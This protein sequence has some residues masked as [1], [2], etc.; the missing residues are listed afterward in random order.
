MS[1]D[2]V[3]LLSIVDAADHLCVSRSKLYELLAAGDL[4]SVRIGRTRRIAMS[5]LIE[6]VERHVET[7]TTTTDPAI[8][9]TR[10]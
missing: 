7:G 6:F 8:D 9:L 4:P 10:S 1:T 2:T 5:A 3:Q